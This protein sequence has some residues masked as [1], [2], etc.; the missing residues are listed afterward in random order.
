MVI[1]GISYSMLPASLEFNFLI[2]WP[3]L[4][5]IALVPLFA[6]LIKKEFCSIALKIAFAKCWCGPIDDP[7]QPSSEMFIIKLV[8][9]LDS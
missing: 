8:F 3:L 1:R 5:I 2:I 6:D 4:L 9:S 7:N